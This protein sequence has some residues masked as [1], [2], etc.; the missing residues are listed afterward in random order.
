MIPA[1]LIEKCIK[2][3][4]EAFK[5]LVDL[6]AGR[7]Y[8]YFY[9][10]TGN[11]E[12]SNDLLSELFVKLVSKISSFKSGYFEQWLFTVASNVFYDH[13]RR[14][15]RDKKL[16]EE[17]AKNL[18]TTSV[19]ES[20]DERLDQLQK[21]L[22]KLDEQTRELIVLRF[23]SDMSFKEIAQLRKEPIGT[24]L[25]KIHRGLAKLRENIEN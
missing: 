23:Y 25:S 21:Q 18:A 22:A 14:Q 1:E 20:D 3:D 6:C 19:D 5:T 10:L 24:V 8:G 16:I 12:I 4:E 17:Q 15:K 2:R 7:F 9:R 11:A 13:L